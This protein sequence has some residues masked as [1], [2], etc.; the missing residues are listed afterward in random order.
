MKMMLLFLMTFGNYFAALV[1]VEMLLYFINSLVYPN[2]YTLGKGTGVGIYTNTAFCVNTAIIL[3]FTFICFFVYKKMGSGSL[4]KMW[5]FLLIM[6][7]LM[8]GCFILHC[9]I[10]TRFKLYFFLL[11]FMLMFLTYI[12]IY[13]LSLNNYKQYAYVGF[14]SIF[15]LIM[16]IAEINICFFLLTIL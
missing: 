9:I 16:F 3:I 6:T 1:F 5:I 15:G 11:D 10:F 4:K 14:I 7:F 12:S 13:C 2:F 8:L